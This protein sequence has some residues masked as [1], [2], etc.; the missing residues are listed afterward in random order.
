MRQNL[1]Q[2]VSD[3]GATTRCADCS[4]FI[5]E[6][7]VEEAPY[8]DAGDQRLL[9]R[10]CWE[11]TQRRAT[12]PPPDPPAQERAGAARHQTWQTY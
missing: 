6:G 2:T 5:G 10:A 1:G 3:F 12:R 11:A 8:E 4:I 9:C 7:H